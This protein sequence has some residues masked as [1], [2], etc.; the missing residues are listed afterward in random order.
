[1]LPVFTPKTLQ[2]KSWA[3]HVLVPASQAK[4]GSVDWELAPRESPASCRSCSMQANLLWL[5]SRTL[6]SHGIPVCQLSGW[7]WSVSLPFLEREEMK[8][9]AN[10]PLYLSEDIC[11]FITEQAFSTGDCLS[12][13]TMHQILPRQGTFLLKIDLLN[14]S[15]AEQAVV[16]HH[17]GWVSTEVRRYRISGCS[18]QPK[19]H[20]KK[21]QENM[22][23][24]AHAP[25]CWAN[26]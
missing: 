24:H 13:L 14:P 11:S 22:H 6:N 20:I 5:H 8:Q 7:T 2:K 21:A 10:H 16:V 17:K 4:C 25:S 9:R 12:L 26:F 15:C 23:A 19:K 18:N 1:M 3:P